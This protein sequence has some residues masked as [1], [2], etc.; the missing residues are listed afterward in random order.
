MLQNYWKVLKK[1]FLVTGSWCVKNTN[2]VISFFSRELSFYF[3]FLAS[4]KKSDS[5]EPVRKKFEKIK[6]LINDHVQTDVLHREG[7]PEVNTIINS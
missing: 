5:S 6:C 3:I 2:C 1:C 4:V 7:I